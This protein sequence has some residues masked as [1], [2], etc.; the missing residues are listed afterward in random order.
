MTPSRPSPAPA[1]SC[2]LCPVTCDRLVYPSGCLQ[3]ACDR[4]YAYEGEGRTYIGCVERV[5]AVEIDLQRFRAAQ[6]TREGFGG[7]RVANEP[8]PMC[9]CGVDRTFPH[10]A[11]E[12]CVHAEF[13]HS[14]PPHLPGVRDTA[15]VPER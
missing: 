9:Q 11:E 8:L 6:A 2:R 13:L 3:S 4:L 12:P 1:G 5:F 10:R 14:A 15:G 7:L